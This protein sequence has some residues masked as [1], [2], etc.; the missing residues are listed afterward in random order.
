AARARQLSG[1]DERLQRPHPFHDRRGAGSVVNRSLLE[2]MTDGEN[3]LVT[4]TGKNPGH[5]RHR[6]VI[7]TRLDE[8]PHPG[9]A[10]APEPLPAGFFDGDDGEVG[11]FASG[12]GAAPHGQA[13]RLAG[14]ITEELG[15][16]FAKQPEPRRACIPC[17]GHDPVSADGLAVRG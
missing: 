1:L 14:V 16:A 5:Y 15:G 11:R 7:E 8:R 12:S 10:L 2:E 9:L 3:L 6:A 4:L 17:T 13:A